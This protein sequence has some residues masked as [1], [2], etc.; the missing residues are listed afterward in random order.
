M[1]DQNTVTVIVPYYRARQTIARA[2]GSALAQTIPPLEIL[3]IDDGSNDHVTDVLAKFGSA[4]KLLRK[5]NGGAASARNLGIDHAIGEWIAFLDA[6]DYWEPCKLER[7]LAH[8]QGAGLIASNW[9]IEFPS[10]VRAVA[11]S[12]NPLFFGRLLRA[13]G[14]EA[15]RVAMSIWTSVALVRRDALGD[16]RFDAGLPTAEDRD[17]W[18]RLAA[19]TPI[20]LVP[21]PLATYVQLQDSLSNSDP[22]RDCGNMLKIVRRH[23]PLLG[24]RNVREQ[25]AIVY[26]RWAGRHLSRGTPRHAIRPAAKRLAIQPASLQAWWILAKALSRSIIP[27]A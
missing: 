27:D 13:H 5:P 20:Y 1:T 19:S 2:V 26:R 3:V 12:E 16:E 14:P 17:L 4:V 21:E 6:D 8:S 9:F 15:F 18:I 25:E 11:K 23:A 22:D 24:P 7:Q 10:K